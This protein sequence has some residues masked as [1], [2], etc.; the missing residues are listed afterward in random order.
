MKGLSGTLHRV[1]LVCVSD[2]DIVLGE[3][4]GVY[5]MQNS[6]VLVRRPWTKESSCFF[7][8]RGRSY[9]DWLLEVC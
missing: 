5:G 9:V 4:L 3:V 8:D 7:I 1:F 2:G 6:L